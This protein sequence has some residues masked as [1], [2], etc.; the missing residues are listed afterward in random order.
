MMKA[1]D[2]RKFRKGIK[3]F[4]LQLAE[5]KLKEI[6]SYYRERAGRKVAQRL[7]NGIVDATVGLNTHSEFGRSSPLLRG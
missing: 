1:T 3:V 6:L 4:W 7:I 5:D 2:L